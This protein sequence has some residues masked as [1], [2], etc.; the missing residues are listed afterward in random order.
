MS[1][2]LK[3]KW[4]CGVDL[5]FFPPQQTGPT[6]GRKMMTGYLASKGVKAS[7]GRVGDMLRKINQPYHV[8]RYHVGIFKEIIDY[9]LLN[10]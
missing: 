7:E 3:L 4:S 2:L 1:Q 10:L 8:A 6:Y 5:D 9:V